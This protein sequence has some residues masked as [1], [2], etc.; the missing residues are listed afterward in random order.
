MPF[1][2]FHDDE[3]MKSMVGATS[4]MSLRVMKPF[5]V[6]FRRIYSFDAL[7]V[8][9]EQIN[10]PSDDKLCFTSV[11]WSFS[12]GRLYLRSTSYQT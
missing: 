11:Q 7:I 8:N 3:K 5:E 4:Q 9:L 1:L 6:L 2:A 10:T 12:T